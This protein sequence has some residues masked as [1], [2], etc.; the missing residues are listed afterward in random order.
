M[1]TP[2]QINE[3]RQKAGIKTANT[4][5]KSQQGNYA[6][7][8]DYLLE[9]P[10][11]KSMG[12]KVFDFFTSSSQK[13]GNT[14]GTAASVID[15]QTNKNRDEALSST[16]K[17][18]DNYLRIAKL[19]PDKERATKFLEAAKNLADTNKIDIFNNPEY[20]KTAKQVIGEGIG[21]A[22]EVTSL[23]TFGGTSKIPTVLKP[24]LSPA[25]K[26]LGGAIDGAK[27]GSAFGGAFGVAGALQENKSTKDILKEGASGAITG[28]VGGAVLGGGISAI[29]TGSSAAL[30]RGK[31]FTQFA[32]NK[33]GGVVEYKLQQ[34]SRDLVKMSPTATKLEARWGKNTPQFIIDEGI[35]PL[36]D[37]DGKKLVTKEAVDALK[38]K[39]SAEATLF[40]KV[41]ADSGEYISLESYRKQLLNEV[42]SKYKNK[43]SDVDSAEAYI[44]KE[45]NSL[46]KNY[47]GDGFAQGDDLLVRVDT[48]NEIKSGSWSKTSSFNATQADKLQSD[49]NYQMGHVARD[50]IEETVTDAGTKQMSQRLGDFISA[51]K[52]LENAEGKT[53]PGGFFGRQFAKIAGTIAGSGG[54]LPGSIIGNL[55]GGALADIANNPKTKTSILYKLHNALNK[56]PE[57]RSIIDEATAILKQR[58]EERSARKLLEAPKFIP[59]G[60]K[61][62]TSRLLTQ[63]EAQE[64]INSYQ[65]LE[66]QKLLK[67]P[68]GDKTNPIILKNKERTALVPEVKK[69]QSAEDALKSPEMKARWAEVNKSMGN[70][71]VTKTSNNLYHTTSA[72]NLQSIAKD[73]LT[74]GNKPRFEGVSGK[75]NISFSANEKGASY[76]GKN[77]D[78]MIRTKTS[79]KPDDLEIDML[80]GGEGIYITHKN[81]P[82]KFL[83]VKING[84]WQPLTDIYNKAKRK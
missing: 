26:V 36:I 39:Y 51:I 34:T 13:F 48:F 3:I 6:G 66:P 77:G 10:K 55:T 74:T 40:N 53:V 27:I 15:P 63:Q 44:N 24:I 41:L 72:Q 58:G 22:L 80:A 7:R 75:N 8:F 31:E 23:G 68:L 82:P 2:E 30:N 32:K 33:L 76:Y 47:E 65:K 37:S 19:E 69:F 5:T 45:I 64:L 84:K 49:I 46:K 17:Q 20:Q 11:E 25:K 61:T 81:I 57:G 52:V 9:K 38:E 42:K 28:G 29:G 83:E 50:I 79:Y 35:L 67:A 56:T 21:T 12:R 78:V 60:S 43:G 73:G 14:L 16:Q 4:S 18:V 70:K 71:K 54:G 1:L 62:D 59:L